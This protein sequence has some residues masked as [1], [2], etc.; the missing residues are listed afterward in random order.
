MSIRTSRIR[1]S[2]SGLAVLLVAVSSRAGTSGRNVSS[3]GIPEPFPQQ[4]LQQ[5]SPLWTASEDGFAASERAAWIIDDGDGTYHLSWWPW[6]ATVRQ[7]AWR[8]RPVPGHAVGILHTHP[9]KVSPKPSM[10]DGPS[11]QNTAKAM[12]MPVYVLHRR[13]IWKIEPGAKAPLRVEDRRWRER[14]RRST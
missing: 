11:D 2:F 3:T 1:F 7:E 13:G 14:L 6:S 5:C 4:L 12:R 10:K 8:H 9:N